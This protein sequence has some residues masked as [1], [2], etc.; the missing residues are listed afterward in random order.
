[1]K[2]VIV[3]V[4]DPKSIVLF[5]NGRIGAVPTPAECHVGMV[6]TV[7]YNN[8]LR[9][10]AFALAAVLLIGLGVFIGITV[11]KGKDTTA[12]AAGMADAG[13]G[14]AFTVEQAKILPDDSYVEL[15]GTIDRFLGDEKY[16]FRDATGSITIEIDHKN[17]RDFSVGDTVRITGEVDV[18]NKGTVIDV[19]TI[20]RSV[21][22]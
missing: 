19:K 10:A 18:D 6:V 22:P 14:S 15:T 8:K 16:V 11:V 5:N 2:G 12:P 7:K 1:M 3:Q 17:R 21:A 9:I 13:R 4:G 20:S